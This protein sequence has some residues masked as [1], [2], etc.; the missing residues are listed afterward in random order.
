MNSSFSSRDVRPE[1]YQTAPGTIFPTLS[2]FLSVCISS[3]QT[4][5]SGGGVCR[6]LFVEGVTGQERFLFALFL[7]A[8]MQASVFVGVGADHLRDG[9]RG[10]LMF[11][12]CFTAVLQNKL[13]S[14]TSAL[15]ILA[16]PDQL[17][18]NQLWRSLPN[19]LLKT[20]RLQL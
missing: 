5:Q 19:S 3:S 6:L 20:Y 10:H 8:F 17:L 14:G 1:S 12:V 16:L 2:Y 15:C 11:S 18:L 4:A 13:V 9:S 7:C